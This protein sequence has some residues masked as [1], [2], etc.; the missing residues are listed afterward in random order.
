MKTPAS[1]RTSNASRDRLHNTAARLRHHRKWRVYERIAC[2]SC[3]SCRSRRLQ[4]AVASDTRRMNHLRWLPP[5]CARPHRASFRTP[6]GTKTPSS[7]A[8]KNGLTL[9]ASTKFYRFIMVSSD[10]RFNAGMLAQDSY[11]T[12]DLDRQF[13]NSGFGVVGRYALPIPVPRAMCSNMSLR[14]ERS[15]ASVQFFPISLNPVVA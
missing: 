14:L 1:A 15:L 4:F 10:R 11:L 12:T 3:C 13:V 9:T 6:K 7:R 8:P 2:R 5:R